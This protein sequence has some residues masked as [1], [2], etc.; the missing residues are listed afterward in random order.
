MAGNVI[1]TSVK[2][3]GEATKMAIRSGG[4]RAR[5]VGEIAVRRLQPN[6]IPPEVLERLPPDFLGMM[7]R[8][9]F[10]KE[11]GVGRVA[12]V[13]DLIDPDDVFE[14]EATLKARVSSRVQTWVELGMA[15][16]DTVVE[17]RPVASREDIDNP[18]LNDRL[19]DR[20]ERTA[21]FARRA[22]AHDHD[23][24]A[25]PVPDPITP[26]ERQDSPMDIPARRATWRDMTTDLILSS[27][28]PDDRSQRPP[29]RV[30]FMGSPHSSA[31]LEGWG[32]ERLFLQNYGTLILKRVATL[33]EDNLL[34]PVSGAEISEDPDS[35]APVW[36]P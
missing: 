21:W 34:V 28:Q 29:T 13:G 36:V 27:K 9:A 7:E 15:R 18:V 11:Y 24:T 5:R 30:H 1:G 26:V 17:F 2:L 31:I 33:P 14:D 8:Q 22:L 23:V 16:P 20:F 32:G 19:N 3:T 10:L 12:M 4:H 6:D 25:I 35:S